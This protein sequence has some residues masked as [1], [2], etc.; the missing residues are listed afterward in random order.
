LPYAPVADGR[1]IAERLSGRLPLP[2]A[3]ARRR[4]SR[5]V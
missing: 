4:R 3:L 2:P 5:V 1:A